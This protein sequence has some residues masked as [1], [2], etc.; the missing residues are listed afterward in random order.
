MERISSITIG[1]LNKEQLKELLNTF[2]LAEIKET[3]TVDDLRNILRKLRKV[4]QDYKAKLVKTRKETEENE[5]NKIDKNKTAVDTKENFENAE[6]VSER[7]EIITETHTQPE[8]DSN[9]DKHVDMEY[10]KT[11]YTW[12]EFVMKWEFYFEGHETPKKRQTSLFLTKSGH[13]IFKLS[14]DL[15]APDKPNTKT[16]EELTKLIGEH[17]CPRKNEQMERYNF[18]LAAQKQ[19][20]SISGFVA[21]LKDL[22]LNCKFDNL[23]DMLRDKFVCGVA[24]QD[25]RVALFSEKNLDYKKAV[26]IAMTREAAVKN[27][28]Q[29]H[30]QGA[31]ASVQHLN[32][33]PQQYRSKNL[34]S[35][36]NQRIKSQQGGKYNKNFNNDDNNNIKNANL[37]CYCCGKNNHTTNNCRIKNNATCNFCKKMGHLEIACITKKK[38]LSKNN[39]TKNSKN[40]HLLEEDSDFDT[41]EN[42]AKCNKIKSSNRNFDTDFYTIN[43]E[44]DYSWQ[45]DLTCNKIMAE[46]L[47]TEVKINDKVIS[48]EV[49]TGTYVTVISENDKNKFFS[50]INL[51]NVNIILSTYGDKQL[52]PLGKLTNLKVQFNNQ[53]KY[54]D[55]QGVTKRPPFLVTGGS[56]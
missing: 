13:E 27:A 11:K 46:P 17:F 20:E 42:N 44:I 43:F 22:S 10:D 25:T 35:H 7:E 49:D 53:T 50:D 51:D 39:N 5:E 48:M 15:C 33:Q 52:Q 3:L 47:F 8:D 21:R 38:S 18:S 23:E 32:S 19:N 28:S 12:D 26:D 41:Y 37:Y 34:Y 1:N 56:G 40:M 45:N 14:I 55:I 54:L 4:Q 31:Q 6:T 16:F 30:K 29:T 24:D 36:N 9:M 2:T